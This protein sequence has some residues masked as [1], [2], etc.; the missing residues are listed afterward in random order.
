MNNSNLNISYKELIDFLHKNQIEYKIVDRN[1]NR[2]KVLFKLNLKSYVSESHIADNFEFILT[3]RHDSEEL[4]Y[5]I[6]TST[7]SEIPFHPH[8]EIQR[9]FF[10]STSKIA[11]W[12]DY[13]KAK[14]DVVTFLK[15]MI[16]S[17]QFN[18]GYIDITHQNDVVNK[19]AE[20]WYLRNLKKKEF[21][22]DILFSNPIKVDS[23]AKKKFDIGG[24]QKINR[25]FKINEELNYSISNKNFKDFD[26]RFDEK[27]DS[28]N[29]SNNITTSLV[30][31]QKAKEDIFS[32]IEWGNKIAVDNK[33]EQGGIL[34]GKVYKDS[35]LNIQ[36]GIVEKAIYSL[37]SN[38]N[39][40]Y[41]EMN[42]EAWSSML[43]Q[44]DLYI[45]VN[46]DENL[47][48][49]G[50]YH[51]HPN[52]L[53][54]FMS[55]TDINT[56]RNYFS[57]PWHYALVL[58][59]QKEIWRAFVGSDAKECKG[60]IIKSKDQETLSSPLETGTDQPWISRKKLMIST[61]L[62]LLVCFLAIFSS[63]LSGNK[64]AVSNGSAKTVEGTRSN[65]YYILAD[66][67]DSLKVISKFKYLNK[68]NGL[69]KFQLAIDTTNCYN[70]KDSIWCVTQKEIYVS[71][72]SGNYTLFGEFTAPYEIKYSRL[73]Q[74][75]SLYIWEINGELKNE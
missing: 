5:F 44:A 11:V 47:Q 6:E 72:E 68:L 24:K 17:L 57:Q 7:T 10:L 29:Q 69:K 19:E 67:K 26:F 16:M 51:T 55:H 27:L 48:V 8:F 30:I 36:Y 46:P 40:V 35:Q 21:P 59:P 71:I 43:D 15:R 12:R 56:Q 14:E 4:E 45:D 62:V 54:V 38:G 66:S 22:T 42:H 64:K 34:L 28:I 3:V 75:S 23:V 49:I 2:Y 20:I 37:S 41:L 32:H 1:D 60:Q 63:I 73:S 18:S 65:D 25:K 50:W 74:D 52:N 13:M 33:V 31:T 9:K 39:Q 70:Q 53:D 61:G 58:N